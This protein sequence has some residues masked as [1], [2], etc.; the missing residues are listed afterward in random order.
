MNLGPMDLK[1]WRDLT[2]RA[3]EIT[4][5]G[6]RLDHC[7]SRDL[8][9]LKSFN[10]KKIKLVLYEFGSNGLETLGKFD[11]EGFENN[12]RKELFESIYFSRSEFSEKLKFQKLTKTKIFTNFESN[13]MKL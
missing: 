5:E 11:W 8:N 1:L 9:F 10:L 3:L 4:T 12:Y 6:N 2:E 7:I 13:K